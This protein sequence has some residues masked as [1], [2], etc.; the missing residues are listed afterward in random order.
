L[1]A[2]KGGIGGGVPPQIQPSPG[3]PERKAA[4]R[5]QQ[6]VLD[7]MHT[8]PESAQKAIKELLDQEH[9]EELDAREASG[10]IASGLANRN[11]ETQS[12]PIGKG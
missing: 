11:D 4:G 8:L 2:P 6:R 12:I 7:M 3:L 10:G 5:R 1:A 9:Q